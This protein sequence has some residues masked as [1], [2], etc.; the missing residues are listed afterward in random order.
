MESQQTHLTL[1]QSDLSNSLSFMS[2]R[3]MLDDKSI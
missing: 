1:I 3:S 2:A